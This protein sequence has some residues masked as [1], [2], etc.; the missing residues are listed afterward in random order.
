M[1]ETGLLILFARSFFAVFD[2]RICK[3]CISTTAHC[4]RSLTQRQRWEC[5]IWIRCSTASPSAM[6]ENPVR[7]PCSL[8]RAGGSEG[9]RP[10][11]LLVARP[12]DHPKRRTLHTPG[13]DSSVCNIN[14]HLLQSRA[15][16]GVKA[17]MDC[18]SERAKNCVTF[19]C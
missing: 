7:C 3:S 1:R 13:S 17:R 16:D 4:F 14:P 10:S 12:K 5:T 8:V 2:R 15:T 9:I 18:V 6:L 11:D 19:N